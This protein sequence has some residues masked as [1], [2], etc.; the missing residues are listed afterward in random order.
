MN[1]EEKINKSVVFKLCQLWY[2]FLIMWRKN[3]KKKLASHFILIRAVNYCKFGG[4][5]TIVKVS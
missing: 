3:G 2:I 4:Y 5:A 1:T